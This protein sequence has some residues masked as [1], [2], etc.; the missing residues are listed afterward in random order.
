MYDLSLKKSLTGTE[1]SFLDHGY[2]ICKYPGIWISVH[3]CVKVKNGK[4]HARRKESCIHLDNVLFFSVQ[5]LP[6]IIST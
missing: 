2:L 3:S 4:W 5:E 6:I 1:L